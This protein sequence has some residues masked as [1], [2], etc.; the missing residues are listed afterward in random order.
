MPET[1]SDVKT[2]MQAYVDSMITS[3][4]G[5]KKDRTGAVDVMKK[6]FGATA[7][8][9]FDEALDFC[10]NEVTPP[11]AFPR[12]ELFVDAQTTSAKTNSK[13]KDLDASGTR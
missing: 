11:L 8:K 5:M 12:P 7:T 13:I 4:A 2:A 9:G 6:Y 1:N 3:T 10:L